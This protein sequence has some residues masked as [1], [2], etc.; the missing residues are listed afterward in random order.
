MLMT[1]LALIIGAVLLGCASIFTIIMILTVIMG[2]YNGYV[3]FCRASRDR[4][5]KSPR[6]I[7]TIQRPS[8]NAIEA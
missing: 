4:F 1:F 5:V 7:P 8:S 6:Q 2:T 3:A